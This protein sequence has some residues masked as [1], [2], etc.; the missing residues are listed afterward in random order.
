[1][2]Y[3]VTFNPSIDYIV[4]VDHFKTGQVNRTTGEIMFPGGKGINVSMVLQ[5]LGFESTAL[6]FMAGFTGDEIARLLQVKNVQ[7]D[8]IRVSEGMSRINVKL[9]SDEE[10]EINGQGP[11]IKDEDIAKLY[12]QLDHLKEGDVLVLAGS[13]PSVMPSSSYED[14]MAHLDGKG[15]KIVVDA[16]NDL[17]VNVLKYHPFLVKPNNHELGEIFGVELKT[18]EE[19]IPYAKKLQEMGAVNVMISMAGDGGLLISENGDVFETMPPKGKIVNSVGA[20]DSMVAG[21][22]AGYLATGDYETAF[23]QGICTGSA[24]AFSENLATKPEVDAL[25]AQ[26]GR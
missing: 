9:R 10:S 20:G 3:T 4:D 17:L 16:T 12:A 19:V 1:M 21:F 2:I 23:Y 24:S 15:I 6:G 18:K 5:N 7:S 22:V 11:A 26:L 25:L 8:F 14:I 13:I